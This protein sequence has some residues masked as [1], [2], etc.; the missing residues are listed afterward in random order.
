MWN[1]T[2]PT[3]IRHCSCLDKNQGAKHPPDVLGSPEER[4]ECLHYFATTPSAMMTAL[5]AAPRRSW[6]PETKN[7]SPWSPKTRLWRMRPTSTSYC[8][9]A[10]KGIG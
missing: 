10:F 9:V 3:A 8:P 1:K 2:N 6:S 4:D 5:S 7:S